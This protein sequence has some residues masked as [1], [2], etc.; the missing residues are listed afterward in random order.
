MKT[1]ILVWSIITGI[2]SALMGYIVFENPPL[3]VGII[4]FIL[5]IPMNYLVWKFKP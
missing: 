4:G 2:C 1:E 5:A 3:I